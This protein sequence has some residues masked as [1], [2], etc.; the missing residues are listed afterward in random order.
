MQVPALAGQ[1]RSQQALGPCFD[2]LCWRH[3]IFPCQL[4]GEC[5]HRLQVVIIG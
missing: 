2:P 5:E 4:G 3:G 1:N